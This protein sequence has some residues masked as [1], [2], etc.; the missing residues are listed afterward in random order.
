MLRRTDWPAIFSRNPRHEFPRQQA[1]SDLPASPG[2]DRLD[3]PE[4]LSGFPH[5]NRHLMA[6]CPSSMG[7]CITPL[8]DRISSFMS[9]ALFGDVSDVPLDTKS[10]R[11][12]CLASGRRGSAAGSF[13]RKRFQCSAY[14]QTPSPATSGKGRK[15]VLRGVQSIEYNCGLENKLNRNLWIC[16]SEPGSSLPVVHDAVIPRGVSD[17]N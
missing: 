5:T 9:Y 8:S 13:S 14:S 6:L 17:H 11:T 10:R 2:L 12:Y 3:P 1:A 15:N 7:S 16:E 4:T